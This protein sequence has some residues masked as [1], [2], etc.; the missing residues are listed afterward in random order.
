[1]QIFKTISESHMGELSLFR[2]YSGS[3]K[4]GIDYYNSNRNMNERFGQMFLL[5]G[6]IKTQAQ[7]LFA[8]DIAGVVKLKDTHTGNTLCSGDHVS[9]PK[10][11]LPSPISIRL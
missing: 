4:T 6:K 3:V 8:G 5:N 1:M 2:I 9:L 11:D 10:L 7:Q